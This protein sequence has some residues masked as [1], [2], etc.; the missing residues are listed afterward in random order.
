MFQ[1]LFIVKKNHFIKSSCQK[2]TPIKKNGECQAIYCSEEDLNGSICIIDN[3]IIKTQWLNNIIIFNEY[4]YRFTNMIINK[5]G[6]LIIVISPQQLNG[7][8]LFFRLKQN[9]SFYFKD[10]NNKE[11]MSR[12]IVVL[13]NNNIDG[14]LRYES[15]VFLI[16][17]NNDNNKEFLVSISRDFGYMEI[18]DLD[19]KSM[20]S[21]KILVKDYSNFTIYSQKGS[22]IELTFISFSE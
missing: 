13:D 10:E 3:E 21:S 2:E 5:D 4:N 18:Y 14:A 16:R 6:D 8:R 17:I 1:L 19:D 11:V 15:Q 9:G 22:I 7:R 20:P 12:T